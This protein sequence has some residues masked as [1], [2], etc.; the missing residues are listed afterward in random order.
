MAVTHEFPKTGGGTITKTL[1]PPFNDL[2]GQALEMLGFK[3]FEE[4]MRDENAVLGAVRK[5]DVTLDPEKREKMCG[6]IFIGG[7]DDI[8]FSK[9]HDLSVMGRAMNDFFGQLA[10]IFLVPVRNLATPRE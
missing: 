3:S 2:T 5:M 7:A 10:G 6:I 9:Q 4:M 8:D 1:N